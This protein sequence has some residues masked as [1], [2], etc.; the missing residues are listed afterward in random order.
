MTDLLSAGLT[1]PLSPTVQGGGG[2][3]ALKVGSLFFPVRLLRLCTYVCMRVC[4]RVCACVCVCDREGGGDRCSK[5]VVCVCV[6]AKT[7]PTSTTII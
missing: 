5:M 4:V 6:C 3:K 1:F 2:I 7:S